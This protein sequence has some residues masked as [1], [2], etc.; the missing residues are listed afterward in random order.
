MN[1]IFK[2]KKIIDFID[3]YRWILVF[4]CGIP[5]FNDTYVPI[6]SL[7]D[8]YMD[9]LKVFVVLLL[10]FLIF[11]RKKK[12]SPLAIVLII[13]EAWWMITTAINYPLSNQEAFYKTTI[14]IADILAM[15]LIV[16]YFLDTPEHLIKGLMLNME[17][18]IYPNFVTVILQNIPGDRYYLIGF[19]AV[20]ILWLL[21]AICVGAMHI[22]LNKG[23]IRGSLLIAFS[24]LTSTVGFAVGSSSISQTALF[25]QCC[26]IDYLN[27]TKV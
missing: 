22:I 18:A 10:A 19:Y 1:N 2:N 12:I 6:Q 21:P 11:I 24:L 16:E 25:D 26:A 8:R 27:M 14:D 13:Y 5:F 4:L 3:K 9:H 15:F 17:L 23:Y 20:L 7:L